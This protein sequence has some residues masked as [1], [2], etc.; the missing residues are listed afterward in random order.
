[1]L[2]MVAVSSATAVSSGAIVGRV[3]DEQGAGLPGIS[4]RVGRAGE[5][6]IAL[7]KTDI[8]GYYAVDGVLSADD[9]RIRLDS[10]GFFPVEVWPV[11]V[12]EGS[13]VHQ[14]IV[15][16]SDEAARVSI[17]IGGRTFNE[18]EAKVYLDAEEGIAAAI[19]RD[20]TIAGVAAALRMIEDLPDVIKEDARVAL[21]L[22]IGNLLRD[23]VEPGD[24][25]MFELL[26]DPDEAVQ[27]MASHVL[28]NQDSEGWLQ[29]PDL[30]ALLQELLNPPADNMVVG[31]LMAYVLAGRF[32]E[33]RSR[34]L[35]LADSPDDAL[36][37]DAASVIAWS[38][39]HH[40]DVA[41]LRWLFHQSSGVLRQTA[42][43]WLANEWDERFPPD[44]S[45]EVTADLVMVMEDSSLTADFRGDAIKAAGRFNREPLLEDALLRLLE[46]EAWFTGVPGVCH[47][48][49]SLTVVLEALER[50][51][52]GPRLVDALVIL[53]NRLDLLD[54]SHRSQV[55]AAIDRILAKQRPP[56]P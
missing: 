29:D 53:K 33:V 1:M 51:G 42:A 19:T 9:Y 40:G 48:R 24:D 44:E 8:A 47:P 35:D 14:D 7:V 13:P 26:R 52:A 23:I 41:G 5:P 45:A 36:A 18:L 10:P 43:I 21:Q 30:R 46:P 55:E 2:T 49:H 54:A 28:L 6:D 39:G 4:I 56:Q 32:D 12:Q 16:R 22:K 50:S 37:H 3:S 27:R 20:P 11:I 34:A 15:L 25:I 31:I 38:H 17:S